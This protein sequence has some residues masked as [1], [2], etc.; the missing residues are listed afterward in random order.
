M[1]CTTCENLPLP[2]NVA[3]SCKACVTGQTAYF[4]YKLCDDCS[5]KMDQCERCESPISAPSSPVVAPGSTSLSVTVKDKDN[6]TTLKDMHPGEEVIVILEEDQYSQ[7]E[8]GVDYASRSL[9]SL[10]SQG[11]FV[12]YPNQYQKGTREFIFEITNSG[13]GDIE[14]EEKVRAYGWWY[15]SGSASTT[16]APNGKKWKITV[17]SK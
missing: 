9:F 16:T 3:G 2:T 12:P 7:T 13:N 14:M 10:K 8:W 1:L 11:P 5:E 17:H 15:Q 4:A 6:G